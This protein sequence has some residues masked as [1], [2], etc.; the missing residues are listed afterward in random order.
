MKLNSL[1]DRVDLLCRQLQIMATRESFICH[2]EF[3]TICVTPV[4]Y[5]DT[6]FSWDKIQN[7]LHGVWDNSNMS[8]DLN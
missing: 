6:K 3:K 7:H 8:L 5:N 4:P 1:K 2:A